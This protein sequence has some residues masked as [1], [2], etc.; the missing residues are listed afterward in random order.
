MDG[1]TM[2]QTV[3]LVAVKLN[4]SIPDNTFKTFIPEINMT[5]SDEVMIHGGEV[6]VEAVKPDEE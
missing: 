5:I 4:V 1:V 6:E 3:Y 2:M